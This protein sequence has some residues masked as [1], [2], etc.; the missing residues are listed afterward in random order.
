MRLTFPLA[1][2]FSLR[3]IEYGTHQINCWKLTLTFHVMLRASFNTNT[4]NCEMLFLKGDILKIH[5][6]SRM[7]ITHTRTRS[8]WRIFGSFVNHTVDSIEKG[9]GQSSVVRD[10]QPMSLLSVRKFL[11]TGH[12]KVLLHCSG[13]SNKN[14]SRIRGLLWFRHQGALKYCLTGNMAP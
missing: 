14:V 7:H 2:V 11:R 6:T 8:A 10:M 5:I 3:Y 1:V 12:E 9:G 4:L 13:L